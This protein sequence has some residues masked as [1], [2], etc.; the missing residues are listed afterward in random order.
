M[1]LSSNFQLFLFIYLAPFFPSFAAFTL[2][3]TIPAG[4][5]I[6]LALFSSIEFGVSCILFAAV[7]RGRMSGENQI[8]AEYASRTVLGLPLTIY[9]SMIFPYGFVSMLRFL[10]FLFYLGG[11]KKYSLLSWY[12]IFFMSGL[13]FFSSLMGE[14]GFPGNQ[15]IVLALSGGSFGVFAARFGWKSH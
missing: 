10:P 2:L 1:Q 4:V 8:Y 6:S 13:L 15:E 5:L 14:T 7:R 9:Y 11:E 12:T 3:D